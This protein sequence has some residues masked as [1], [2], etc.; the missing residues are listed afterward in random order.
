[1]PHCYGSRRF[2]TMHNTDHPWLCK[3][4]LKPAYIISLI[5]LGISQYYSPT[6]SQVL[7]T[8]LPVQKSKF[9][10]YFRL[11]L[12]C[13]LCT[14][15][16]IL[17]NYL[18]IWFIVPAVKVFGLMLIH[19]NTD[20]FYEHAESTARWSVTLNSATCKITEYNERDT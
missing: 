14:F 19:F 12:M 6:Y 15:N 11:S 13:P 17:S 1:M 8:V 3:R 5:F 4:Q 7:Q 10:H 2:I 20:L 16:F 18:S 9:C